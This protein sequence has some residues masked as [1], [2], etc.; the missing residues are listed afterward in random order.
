MDISISTPPIYSLPPELHQ[1]VVAQLPYL[2]AWSLKQ[3]STLFYTRVRIP[4]L[5]A[6]LIAL[7]MNCNRSSGNCDHTVYATLKAAGIISIDKEP[8]GYCKRLRPL[9]LFAKAFRRLMAARSRGSGQEFDANSQWCV[10]CGFHHQRYGRGDRIPMGYAIVNAD[11]I[12]ATDCWRCA[13]I[14][15]YR[16]TCRT[17]RQ[18][19]YCIDTLDNVRESAKMDQPRLCSA[20]REH[21]SIARIYRSSHNLIRGA[22]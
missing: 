11:S 18:C 14:V 1:M 22:S 10:E 7:N 20:Y 2:D 3:T 16:L 6:F 15:D 12:A 21:Q 8:C 9:S 5:Q 17:C 4:T 13:R 19:A